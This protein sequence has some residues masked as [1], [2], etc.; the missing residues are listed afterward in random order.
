MSPS[1][2]SSAVQRS[3]ISSDT[4]IA[5]SEVGQ[6]GGHLGA[7]L[8][9]E[10]LR[11]EAEALRVAQEVARLDGQEGL[12]RVGVLP[13][14]VVR[15]AGRHERQPGVGGQRPEAGVDAG[16]DLQP[17]VLD[18]HVD[19]VAAEDLRERVE[20]GARGGVVG[21]L[22]ARADDA[23]QASREG[24]DPVGVARHELV[25]DARLAV[26]ALE[27]AGRAELDEVVVALGGLGEQR[28]VVAPLAARPLGVV[29][30]HVGL[31]P[32]HRR[33]PALG[34]LAVQLDGA[35]HHAVVRQRDGRLAHPLDDV[36]EPVDL[37]GPVEHRVVR[38]DVEVDEGRV[39]GRAPG[40]EAT[41]DTGPDKTRP[42]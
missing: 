17:R 41:A 5:S 20:L 15:V 30:D 23:G 11:L 28:Q 34:G 12:V 35:A 36:Q 7:G 31:E 27:V 2:S 21:A 4:G 8:E 25:G 10:L 14:R 13:A 39:G 18:L 40:A 38:V 22:E 26:V 24:D 37:A 32:D 42:R 1:G 16:L 33:D 3:A 6:R 29:G 9:V 19:V